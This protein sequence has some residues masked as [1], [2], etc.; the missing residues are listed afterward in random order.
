[1]IYLS[2]LISLKLSIFKK[3]CLAG[4]S[5][6]VISKYHLKIVTI[7][8]QIILPNSL[9]DLENEVFSECEKL[10][11]IYIQAGEEFI[12]K[13]VL[14]GCPNLKEI[15]VDP[16][17]PYFDSRE[18]CNAIIDSKTGKLII[19]CNVTVIPNSVTS[20]G[21]NAF[22]G[23]GIE[24]ITIPESVTEIGESAFEKCLS[25]KIVTLPSSVTSINDRAFYDCM[26]LSSMA[27]QSKLKRVGT[28]LSLL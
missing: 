9:E 25:L 5:I 17:N 23:S 12:G 6:F 7:L 11:R 2:T 16:N 27:L 3:N 19:G 4:R 24:S 13:K 26:E 18:N 28:E 20:I 21:E 15:T 8:Q 1:M 22:L 14:S 10:E